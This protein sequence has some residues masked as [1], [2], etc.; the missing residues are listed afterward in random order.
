M[1]QGLGGQGQPLGSAGYTSPR[2]DTHLPP[3]LGQDPAP[4]SGTSR[5]C[6]IYSILAYWPHA[7]GTSLSRWLE[8]SSTVLSIC[9]VSWTHRI[10]ESDELA[11]LSC[12]LL[13]GLWGGVL[14]YG[15]GVSRHRF[16]F[17]LIHLFVCVYETFNVICSPGPSVSHL[18]IGDHRTFSE[19]RV[20]ISK[21]MCIKPLE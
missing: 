12:V 11:F 19:G 1:A 15:L 21:I 3:V 16:K 8:S 14:E 9:S 2:W 4:K 6:L 17:W 20:R 18:G 10:C 13:R 7:Q 5:L